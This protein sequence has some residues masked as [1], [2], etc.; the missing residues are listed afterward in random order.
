ME[1]QYHNNY[2]YES[3]HLFG[4][5][6]TSKNISELNTHFVAENSRNEF[7]IFIEKYNIFEN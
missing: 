3:F 6:L 4:F 5:A 2:F 7:R 1:I